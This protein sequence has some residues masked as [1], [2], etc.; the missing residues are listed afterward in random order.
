[1][2]EALYW[3]LVTGEFPSNQE[4]HDLQNEF[5]ERSQLDSE[6]IKFLTSLPKEA[7]PMTML[8]QSLLYLQKDSTFSKLYSQGRISK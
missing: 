1:M 5:R 7:H 3:L 6:T 4:F 8:S 2:P